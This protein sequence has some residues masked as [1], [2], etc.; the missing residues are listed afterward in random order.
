MLLVKAD[1][2][3][4]VSRQP[5]VFEAFCSYGADRCQMTDGGG[6]CIVMQMLDPVLKTVEQ[7]LQTTFTVNDSIFGSQ[8]PPET[9]KA[10][11]RHLDGKTDVC[12]P[13]NGS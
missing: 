1:Y 7:N 10:V 5:I 11:E 9:I 2:L 6:E 8:Q 4:L 3:S 13:C 12:C